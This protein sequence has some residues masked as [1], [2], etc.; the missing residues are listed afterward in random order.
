MSGGNQAILLTKIGTIVITGNSKTLLL[1]PEIVNTVN[2]PS[3]SFLTNGNELLNFNET[4]GIIE[5]LDDGILQISS[6]INAKATQ[7]TGD[8]IMIPEYN[9]QGGGWY[10][11]A[12]RKEVLTAIKPTQVLLQGS[13]MFF[14]NDLIRFNAYSGSGS[15]TL[16][17]QVLNQGLPLQ[18]VLPAAILYFTMNRITAGLK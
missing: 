15:I 14:K 10:P 17:T 5:I 7:A 3:L 4:S 1:T 12:P 9:E 8:F 11:S 13:K 18:T 6:V 2:F 16:Q